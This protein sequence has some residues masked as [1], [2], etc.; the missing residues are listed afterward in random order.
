MVDDGVAELVAIGL[1]VTVA[2]VALAVGLGGEG[3]LALAALVRPLAVV[4]PHVPDQRP[5]VVA[6]LRAHVAAVRRTSQVIP[7]VT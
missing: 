7:I 4:R 5:L 1:A 2:Q 6:P 3:V